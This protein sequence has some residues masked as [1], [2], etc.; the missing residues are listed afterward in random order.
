MKTSIENGDFRFKDSISLLKISDVVITNPPF[1]LF[2]DFILLLY[3]Y[4]KNFLIIGPNNAISYRNIFNL[5]KENKL[6]FGFGFNKTLYFK[7]P[8]YY[9]KIII[10]NG[11]YFC[12]VH[13]SPQ[14]FHLLA[15]HL[16]NVLYA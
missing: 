11:E 13:L 4:N 15:L 7:V 1:S 8:K 3:K 5:I 9:D 2:Q 12:K 16:K 6:W 14:F 10:D